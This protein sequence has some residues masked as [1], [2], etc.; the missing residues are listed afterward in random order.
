M[1]NLGVVFTEMAWLDE[2]AADCAED[3]RYEASSARSPIKVVA[4]TGGSVN[5]V[6]HEITFAVKMNGPS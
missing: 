6:V 1:R 3:R 4:G 5:P 2:L